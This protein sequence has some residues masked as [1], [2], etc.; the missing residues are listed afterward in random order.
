MDI[1]R[2]RFIDVLIIRKRPDIML[3]FSK[4]RKL[5]RNFWAGV[6][7]ENEKT[8]PE[9]LAILKQVESEIRFISYEPLLSDIG[10]PDLTDIQWVITGGESGSHLWKDHIAEQRALVIYDREHKKWFPRPDRMDWIRKIRDI[11]LRDGVKF[12]HKQWGGNYPEA[13]GR[14]LDGR[15]WND[16]PRLP[17]DRQQIDNNYLKHLENKKLGDKEASIMKTLF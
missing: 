10:N 3:A 13:A 1:L 4:E 12:F 8:Q 11:C 7:I 16:I 9:R 5:P 2:N 15:T 14:L 17:G 6:T